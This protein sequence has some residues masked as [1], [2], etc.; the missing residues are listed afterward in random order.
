MRNFCRSK[1]IFRFIE[2]K[3]VI[4]QKNEIMEIYDSQQQKNT[5]L[6]KAALV[7]LEKTLIE[8]KFTEIEDIHK[9]NDGPVFADYKAKSKTGRETYFEIKSTQAETQ[10][11]GR[12][13]AKEIV[14][15]L[16]AV[17]YDYF[18]VIL[19]RLKDK[20]PNDF[21]FV[22]PD[23]LSGPFL[24]LDEMLKY[25]TGNKYAG[26]DILVK[27]PK[28]KKKPLVRNY[29]KD[30][31]WIVFPDDSQGKY[32]KRKLKTKLDVLKGFLEL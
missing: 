19:H 29:D 31:K 23:E 10:S 7:F 6:E 4:L 27:Y 14:S 12:I 1:N 8:Y 17:K 2:E 20:D 16:K 13:S 9:N 3:S 15:A 22:C 21:C 24:T 5:S 26:I 25:T 30:K 11:W 18:F 28:N 32:D